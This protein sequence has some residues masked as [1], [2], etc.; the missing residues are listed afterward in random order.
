[1]QLKV[2]KW[3]SAR[4]GYVAKITEELNVGTSWPYVGTL[5][6]QDGDLVIGNERHLWTPT[7]GYGIDLGSR[8]KW[9]LLTEIAA[10]SWSGEGETLQQKLDAAKAEVTRLE[11]EVRLSKI[12]QEMDVWVNI[13]EDGDF[14]MHRSEDDAK[15]NSGRMM[16]A[17][18]AP[19]KLVR[20]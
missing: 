4:N 16:L 9:D 5:H 11:R 12:P 10:P 15:R 20:K 3:Y 19:Y 2:G 6:K 13:Y 14:Y 7:G 17:T 18:A 8:D 1:M